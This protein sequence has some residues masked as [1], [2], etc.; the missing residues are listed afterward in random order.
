MNPIDPLRPSSLDDI[1]GPVES[2]PAYGGY[3][4]ASAYRPYHWDMP[5]I[6]T[7]QPTAPRFDE[8]R[9]EPPLLPRYEDGLLT[10][11]SFARAMRDLNG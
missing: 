11:D 1:V 9:P 6:E 7:P 10:P 2:G 8:P 4:A 5:W 3:G